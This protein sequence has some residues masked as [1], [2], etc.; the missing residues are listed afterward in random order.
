MALD[1]VV[2]L[3]KSKGYDTILTIMDQGCTKAMI[4]IPCNEAMES[5]EVAELFK[6][7]AFP[8]TGIPQKLISDQDPRFTSTLFKE[9]CTSLDVQHNVSTAYHPQTDGQS[10][11]TNQTMEAILRIFCNHQQDNWAD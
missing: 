1:F 5:A 7:K 2:K 6:E 4:L 11:R 10:E 3:P 9:L 8:Y